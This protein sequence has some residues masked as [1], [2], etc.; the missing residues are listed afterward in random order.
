MLPSAATARQGRLVH[1]R[2]AAAEFQ[3]SRRDAPEGL[4][5]GSTAKAIA[6]NPMPKVSLA[7]RPFLLTSL[8]AAASALGAPARGA[9]SIDINRGNVTPMPIAISPFS[10]DQGQPDELGRE[11][12]GVI[13]ANLERC[14]L[15]R[16][17]EERAFIQT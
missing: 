12:K 10:G 11:F 7:R 16:P 4:M 8:A 5:I 13:S 3:P 6:R 2:R 15:F 9:I 14:G 17:I 1:E